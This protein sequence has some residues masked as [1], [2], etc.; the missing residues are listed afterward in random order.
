MKYGIFAP[1]LRML[2]LPDLLKWCGA[3][4]FQ[5]VELWTCEQEGKGLYNAS[6]LNIADFDQAKADEAKGMMTDAGLEVRCM[7]STMNMLDPRSREQRVPALKRVIDA[8]SLMGMDVVGC[9][10]GRDYDLNLADNI[11]LFGEVFPDICS[12]AA[13]KGIK[14]A[15]E[16][17]PL[18][19][20]KQG[21]VGNIA[22]SPDMWGKM[23]NE[24]P[25]ENLGINYDP[26]HLYWMQIDIYRAIKE[27]GPKIFWVHAKDCEVDEDR[28]AREGNIPFWDMTWSY[29]V[30]GFGKMDWSRMLSL[31]YENG[32][33]DV[34][35]IEFED[36][37]LGYSK[38]PD[39]WIKNEEAIKHALVLGRKYMENWAM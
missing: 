22:F 12:Y 32:Y 13:D 1:A 2:E 36:M 20:E 14:L 8:A 3:N 17:C 34:L 5:T 26:S 37:V 19:W 23:L 10:A 24:V 38:S 39:G 9:W 33:N 4:G 28:L 11:K 21:M 6:Q 15:M 27:F 25:A 31:L 7:S 18:F 29:R 30:P 35:S 16:N